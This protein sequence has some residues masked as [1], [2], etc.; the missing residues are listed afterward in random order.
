MLLDV[1]DRI[2]LARIHSLTAE[3]DCGLAWGKTKPSLPPPE[4]EDGHGSL[5]SIEEIHPRLILVQC[6]SCRR[7]L[8]NLIE[9]KA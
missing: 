5:V 3:K 4:C 6:T 2:T 1:V 9:K 7:W 8:L